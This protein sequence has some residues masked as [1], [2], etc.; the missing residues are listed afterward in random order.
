[1]NKKLTSKILFYFSMIL[2]ILLFSFCS[3]P[4]KKKE[5]VQEVV[6]E[7]T[8]G[9]FQSELDNMTYSEFDYKQIRPK[10][11]IRLAW[12]EKHLSRLKEIAE[13]IPDNYIINL[14]GHDARGS[15]K[16]WPKTVSRYNMGLL[17]SQYLHSLLKVNGLPMDKFIF[18]SEAD[19]KPIE[20]IKH[21]N[22]MNRRVTLHIEEK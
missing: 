18:S 19:K 20:G 17:R 1:M 12:I 16:K 8:V 5:P 3:T 22:P 21:S 4:Q 7:T 6:K 10:K 2:I 15:K 14:K 13:Q 11:K 9:E